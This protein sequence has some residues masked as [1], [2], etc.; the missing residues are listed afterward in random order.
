MAGVMDQSHDAPDSDSRPASQMSNTQTAF[1]TQLQRPTRA[2]ADPVEP[3]VLGVNRLEPVLAGNTKR[4][5]IETGAAD[6]TYEKQ[7][8]LLAM[9]GSRRTQNATNPGPSRPQGFVQSAF[10]RQK[11]SDTAVE[12]SSELPL[13]PPNHDASQSRDEHKIS[14]P[15]PPSP[16][17]RERSDKEVSSRSSR[18]REVRDSAR[19]QHSNDTHPVLHHP[20]DASPECSWMK[21]FIFNSETLK[22][23]RLQQDCLSKD[24]SWLKPHPGCPPFQDGNMPQSILAV[25]HRMADER[26]SAADDGNSDSDS[27]IDPSPD[28]LPVTINLSAESVPQTTQENNEDDNDDNNKDDSSSDEVSNWSASPRSPQRPVKLHQGL[29]PDSSPANQMS[30]GE[31]PSRVLPKT[32]TNL[33][34]SLEVIN[35]SDEEPAPSASSP[36]AVQNPVGSDDEMDMEEFIPQALGEDLTEKTSPCADS[37][38]VFS[39]KPAQL[40]SVVQVRETPYGKGKTVQQMDKFL[41]RKTIPKQAPN[42]SGESKDTSSTSIVHSTNSAPGAPRSEAAQNDADKT[43]TP[44][45][46]TSFSHERREA[47]VATAETGT[48]HSPEDVQLLSGLSDA[49]ETALMFGIEEKPQVSDDPRSQVTSTIKPNTTP[50][51]LKLQGPRSGPSSNTHQAPPGSIKRKLQVSPD[52]DSRRHSK[53]REIKIVGF[54][55]I[56]PVTVDHVAQLR[57]EREESLRRFREERN[58]SIGFDM[59]HPHR[60]TRIPVEK[61]DTDAMNLDTAT[62]DNEIKSEKRSPRHQS[63]YDEPSPPPMRTR[64]VFESFKAAY[65]EYNGDTKHFHNQCKQIYILDLEDK[66]VP[67]WQWDDYIIRNRTDYRDYAMECLDRGENAEPY[68]RFYKDNICD[69]LYRRGVIEGR[70]TIEKALGEVDIAIE[71]LGQ[72][73]RTQSSSRKSFP[74]SFEQT[75]KPRQNHLAALPPRPR[76]SLPSST[77]AHYQQG[78]S[79]ASKHHRSQQQDKPPRKSVPEPTGDPYRDYFF[80]IQRSTSWTG[81]KKVSFC[82]LLLG[83]TLTHQG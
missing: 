8:K 36:L 50:Q 39:P 65:P 53:R 62:S 25:L 33:S 1:G 14:K 4:V 46:E 12:S 24:T 22:V 19:G 21:G 74:G 41:A 72:P 42:S 57:E 81:S 28:S 59:E 7:Q 68:H 54:V 29:P 78:P 23:S 49:E 64:T 55:D 5:E 51:S 31:Q 70:Q 48:A 58:S 75:R 20:T 71:D 30:S 76:Q 32:P 56:S 63:L 66:M 40:Q 80:G 34:Q 69:T 52:K 82:F 83:A 6:A 3:Q 26:V 43:D 79:S 45:G 16:K 17:H 60:P 47:H 9:L 67:K 44:K 15:I 27:D 73:P 13:K 37:P 77:Y 61:P 38:A 11:S 35:I 2:R 18:N 10:A